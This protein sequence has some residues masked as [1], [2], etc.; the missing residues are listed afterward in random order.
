MLPRVLSR[1]VE[2]PPDV[3]DPGPIDSNTVDPGTIDPGTVAAGATAAAST[4]ASTPRR[5]PLERLVGRLSRAGRQ[6]PAD[7]GHTRRSFLTRVAVGGSALAVNPF[8]FILKPGTAYASLCGGGAAC[9]DGWSVFCCTINNGK[10]SCPPGSYLA[11]WWKADNSSFCGGK[12]RYYL[13]CNATCPTSCSCYCPTG[14]CDNRRTCCNQF[15][16]G[17]CHQEIACYGPVVCRMVS[18]TPP[19]QFDPAC[20]STS[21]TDNATA[22]HTAPCVTADDTTNVIVGPAVANNADGRLEIFI[23]G[24]DKTLQESWQLVPNGGWSGWAGRGVSATGTPAVT[25][26]LDGRL[27]AFVIGADGRLRSSWQLAPNSQWS[28]FVPIGT[29]TFPPLAGCA[30]ASNAD[31]RL[32][33][34]AVTADGTLMHAFQTAPGSTWS[35]WWPLPGKFVG[36]PA[37]VTNKDGRLE[38]FITGVDGAMND[39]WQLAPNSGWS[40]YASLGGNW[41][42]QNNPA[43]VCGPSGRLELFV[44]GRDRQIYTAWQVKQNGPWSGWLGFSPG[45]TWRGSPAAAKNQ[46]GRLELFVEGDDRQIWHSWQQTPETASWTGWWPLGGTSI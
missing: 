36:T 30:A 12:A 39:T 16:Y 33:V 38:L 25:R 13:D 8:G 5:S 32:E 11:G 31:G 43:V 41:S 26:N 9:G 35:A 45:R 4:A 1:G 42:P 23:V 44:L 40:G 29:Q 18:C 27:E 28:G 10:N 19:W 20:T 22:T 7:R 37:V 24:A 3:I 17:Q 14:T 15:R 21:A 46:D 2:T 34:F 6:V